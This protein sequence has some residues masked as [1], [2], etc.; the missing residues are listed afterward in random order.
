MNYK[1][2]SKGENW[3][4]FR[5]ILDSI[6]ES[7]TIT[8]IHDGT[9]VLSGDYGLLAFRCEAFSVRFGFPNSETN[10]GYFSEKVCR[11]IKIKDWNFDRAIKDL[12]DDIK[13]T[14]WDDAAHM[15]ECLEKASGFPECETEQ[16]FIARCTETF[17]NT[18]A[19]NYWGM[20]EDY[21]DRFKFQFE[22]LKFW[23][24]FRVQEASDG[25]NKS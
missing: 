9:V 14:C 8:T 19:E 15:R 17:D 3:W 5:K 20:G 11:E 7:F 12:Q 18:D 1:L 21:T 6:E 13:E 16:E 23:S 2:H 10:I 25:T 24:E 22:L 4:H